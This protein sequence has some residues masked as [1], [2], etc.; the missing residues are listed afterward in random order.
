MSETPVAAD[1]ELV[2]FL[3]AP[4]PRVIPAILRR[5]ARREAGSFGL[6]FFGAVFLAMGL[7]FTKIFLPWKQL[8]EWRLAASRPAVAQGQITSVEKTNM[9]INDEQVMRYGFEFAAARGGLVRGECFTTGRRWSPGDAVKVRYDAIKPAL[10]CPAGARLSEGSLESAFVLVFPLVGGGIIGWGI[11][12]R[13][14]MLWVMK[15]GALGDFR[16]TAIEP[17]RVEINEQP[18]FKITLQRIDQAVAQPHE[19]RWSK[20]E[21]LAF[22]RERQ[23]NGQAVFGLF[24]P[25]KPKKVLLPEA[26]MGPG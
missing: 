9:S 5:A 13:R 22:A 15:N 18:Q 26:W 10:A 17:T 21:L 1:E 23:K 7:F 24:D 12:A 25:A 4:V 3:A 8:D 2:R 14:R 19:V 11:Y 20:P 16:V 6:L